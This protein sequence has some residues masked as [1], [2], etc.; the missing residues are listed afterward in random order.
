[1][2]SARAGKTVKKIAWKG[3]RATLLIDDDE[4]TLSENAFSEFRLYVGKELSSSE[5]RK[6]KDYAALDDLYSYGLKLLSAR[7]Y[8]SYE[9][10]GKLMKRSAEIEDIRKVIFR[11]KKNGLLD[12]EAY[13]KGYL[14]DAY[15]L[16]GYGEKRIR[17]ELERKGI[18]PEVVASLPFSYEKEL[19]SAKK[20][21]RQLEKRYA[22]VPNQAKR[23]KIMNALLARGYSNSLA[24]EASGDIEE[25]EEAMEASLLEKDYNKSKARYGRKYQ[26][27]ELKQKL[28]AYLLGKGY[29]YEDIKHMEEDE[30]ENNC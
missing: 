22:S 28:M 24:R 23:D 29:R 20:I 8:T 15:E 14:E 25:N 3:K 5:F 2:P 30:D 9:I 21:S 1:M 26:G 4:V 19:M 6:L 17:F 27:Y 18:P 7:S 10:R 13:A 12:D 11:L 16:K